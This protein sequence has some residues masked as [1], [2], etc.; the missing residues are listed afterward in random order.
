MRRGHKRRGYTRRDKVI[1]E[2]RRRGYTRRD[3]VIR[4]D[5]RRGYKRRDNESVP[6]AHHRPA[7]LG[8]IQ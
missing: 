3:K 8:D 7:A 4:K 2:D 5:R 1:R 6:A